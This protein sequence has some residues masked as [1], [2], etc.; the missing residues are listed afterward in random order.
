MGRTCIPEKTVL[1]LRFMLSN[2]PGDYNIVVTW[3]L[4]DNCLGYKNA[5]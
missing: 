4:A 1:E 2:I 5:W 3:L